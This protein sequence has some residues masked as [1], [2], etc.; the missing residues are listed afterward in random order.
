MSESTGFLP[1]GTVVETEHIPYLLTEKGSLIFT[2][3]PNGHVWGHRVED[4]GIK[5]DI[6]LEVYIPAFGGYTIK[7]KGWDHAAPSWSRGLEL[8]KEQE[9]AISRILGQTALHTTL[10]ALVLP[11]DCINFLKV[12]Y[13]NHAY[14]L[15]PAG[16]GDLL[17]GSSNPV[18]IKLVD[19]LLP[20]QTSKSGF[21]NIA[22]LDDKFT[23]QVSTAY[24]ACAG[25]AAVAN[26]LIK[27]PGIKSDLEFS[28]ADPKGL[29][30]IH[31][32][33]Y[34]FFERGV[35]TE[36]PHYVVFAA[37]AKNKKFFVGHFPACVER[38]LFPNELAVL[39]DTEN[40]FNVF[41]I[42]DALLLLEEKRISETD[43]ELY[44]TFAVA[45]NKVLR[46]HKRLLSNNP[47]LFK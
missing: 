35:N 46:E 38:S 39:L 17:V 8:K 44:W 13:I 2:I 19:C 33:G 26:I 4:D 22:Y 41:E 24:Y 31:K 25:G 10:G 28:N 27:T 43:S 40:V 29:Y 15:L 42:D 34:R 7:R 23:F 36:F 20:N 14:T 21:F 32:Q 1:A 37:Q 30:E 18:K 45:Q 11:F 47:S 6:E 16:R 12:R 9:K 3:A 5:R